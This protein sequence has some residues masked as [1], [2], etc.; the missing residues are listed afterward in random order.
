MI[1]DNYIDKK[2]LD[3]CYKINVNII[4]ITNK[5]NEIDLEKYYKQYN[6]IEIKISKS[7]HDRFIILDKII[8]Y[9]SGASF[10][11]LGKKCFAINKIDNKNILEKLLDE[12]KI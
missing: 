9:H 11:D 1:V 3:I 10:K 2:F 4:I 6:N 7:Y 8:L 12:I 5:I